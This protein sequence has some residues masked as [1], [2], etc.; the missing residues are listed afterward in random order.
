[1]VIGDKLTSSLSPNGLAVSAST[2][3]TGQLSKFARA[4]TI[5]GQTHQ[6]QETTDRF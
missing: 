2:C 4:C 6:L 3:T 1:M 5:P